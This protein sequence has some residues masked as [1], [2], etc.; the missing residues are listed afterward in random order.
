MAFESGRNMPKYNGFF[1]ACSAWKQGG[2]LEATNEGQRLK[3][4]VC[5]RLDGTTESRALIPAE[6]K[7]RLKPARNSFFS[8]SVPPR[9]YRDIQTAEDMHVPS[10][11]MSRTLILFRSC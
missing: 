10:L 7:A 6:A 11:F 2:C 5:V 3:P 1:G 8:H 9:N 4:V